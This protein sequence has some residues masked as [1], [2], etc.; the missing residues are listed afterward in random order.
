[1]KTELV[2]VLSY[3]LALLAGTAYLVGWQDWNPAWFLFTALCLAKY[4]KDDSKG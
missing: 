1:M 2:L 4:K 3:N